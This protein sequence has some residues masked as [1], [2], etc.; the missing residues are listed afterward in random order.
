MFD[1]AGVTKE[2]VVKKIRHTWLAMMTVLVGITLFAGFNQADRPH[3]LELTLRAPES[4]ADVRSRYTQQLIVLALEKTRAEYGDYSL[5]F[6]EP[7]NTAQT[8]EALKAH[9]Y[10]NFVAKLSFDPQLESAG[11]ARGNI[12]IDLD[13]TGYRVCFTRSALLPSLSRVGSLQEL[14]VFSHGQGQGWADVAILKANGLKVKDEADYEHLFRMVS[15]AEV[16]LFCRGV[17]EIV[18]EMRSHSELPN[19]VIEPEL[20]LYYPLPRFLYVNSQDKDLL[21]RLEKGLALARQDGSWM[22]LWL[23]NYAE[24]IESLNLSKRRVVPLTNPLVKALPEFEKRKPA[25]PVLSLF[26]LDSSSANSVR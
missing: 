15:A 24:S 14:A 23:E 18:E 10:H 16:D 8:I 13:M 19:L 12:D 25:I 1:A 17:T 26:D 9:R 6:T 20:L 3:S 4:N 11:L 21:E 2:W 7:R 5:S 22:R